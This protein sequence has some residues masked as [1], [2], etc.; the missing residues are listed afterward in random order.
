M[1]KKAIAE[2]EVLEWLESRVK[3]LHQK[4]RVKFYKSGGVKFLWFLRKG[5][6]SREPAIF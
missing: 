2:L 5:G 1:K 3:E 6:V 4:K